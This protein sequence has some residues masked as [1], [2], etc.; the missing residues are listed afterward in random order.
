MLQVSG[1]RM[2]SSSNRGRGIRGRTGA[3]DRGG[4][5]KRAA[6]PRID[7]DG[8]MDMAASAAGAGRGR[9]RGP[10][11]GAPG[12]SSRRPGE[13]E[14]T[15]D[16]LQKAIFN[17][18]SS[19]ANI[20]H[21]R[22]AML[23]GASRR[24]L[25]QIKVGGW[26]ASKAAS[27]PDGGVVSLIAF[28]EKKAAP[29]DQNATAPGRFKITKSRVE[30]DNMI[31]SV[32]PEQV[33]GF[34]RLN[35]YTFAG[36]PISVEL[37]DGPGAANASSR[38]SQ[39]PSQAAIDTKSKMTSFLAKRYSEPGKLLDLS[40]L[41]TDPDLVE[42]GMFN[43]VTTESKFFPALMKV[44]ELTFDSAAKR[45]AAV[46]S[47]SLAHN[48]LA[49]LTAVTSLAQTFPEIKNLDLSHNQL[50]DIPSLS[51]WRWKF[52]TLD[53]L[54]LTGNPVC[55][56]P[57]F[58]ETIIKWYPQLRTLNNAPV[59]TAEEIAAQ[60]KT[61]IPVMGPSF[62]D[63][64][65]IAE[66]FVKAFF[67]GFDNN[68][69]DLLNGIYDAN[70]IFSYNVNTVAPRAAQTESTPSW[71]AY[72]RK[73]RNLLKISHLPARMSRSFVGTENIREAWNSL[74]QTKH[75]EILSNPK[76]WLIECH[77]IPGL[78][79]INNQSA[80][81][82]GGLL[83]TVHGKFEESYP[84]TADKTQ[85]RSFDRTFVLG[86]GNGL[87][88]LRVS[89]D[90]LCLRVFGDCTAWIPENEQVPVVPQIPPVVTVTPAPSTAIQPAQPIPTPQLPAQHPEAKPGYGIPQ[91]GKTEEQVKQEQLVL[92]ISFKTKMT[93]AFSEMAL[94]GNSWDL[95]L[96]L[97]NF[98]E[99]KAQG[100]LPPN[101]FLPG[102]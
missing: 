51:S 95:N 65:Q 88:G 66:N 82:V 19:Q 57:N 54:D 30:G 24:N 45:K 55:S 32:R 31:I 1:G 73:S 23:D 58:K 56:E 43:S 33:D 52:R 93:L 34:L 99:L 91:P 70:S 98:E 69:N 90:M 92:E 26:K 76:E 64:G 5:R 29:M 21:G 3:T 48:Q 62:Q 41:G 25:T 50:K 6:T 94:S 15:I 28:L 53:F 74:P 22:G 39:G 68:R 102:A 100:N 75:P 72:I 83:I 14:K 85:T 37:H 67:A 60:K 7:R 49:S 18:S 77:P 36:A 9:G 81:G 61:P 86:P 38:P 97:K 96:A 44:C 42:M 20:R 10:R 59:R 2:N 101:A 17:S 12:R 35:G 46:E 78:P 11:G 47:V 84:G 87:G 27:N 13:K 80:T 16:A 8:D 71:D 89:N 63:E 40:K 79:D 4:I